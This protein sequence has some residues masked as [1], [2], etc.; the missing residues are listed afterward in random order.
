MNL[1]GDLDF[2]C[3][4]LYSMPS[5]GKDDYITFSHHSTAQASEIVYLELSISR[6]RVMFTVESKI[7]Q[8]KIYLFV[9]TQK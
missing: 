9:V 4:I 3:Q 2:R 8:N 7:E 5:Q 1:L 6:L